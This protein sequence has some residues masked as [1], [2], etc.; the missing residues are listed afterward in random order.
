ML[1]KIVYLHAVKGVCESVGLA[2]LILNLGYTPGKEPPLSKILVL[3]QSRF[4]LELVTNEH[5]FCNDS[6]HCASRLA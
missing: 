5:M 3:P 4:S 6:P 2:A 1:V